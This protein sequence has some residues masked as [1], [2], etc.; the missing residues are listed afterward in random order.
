MH[1]NCDFFR[2]V[3]QLY[4]QS[5]YVCLSDRPSC[6]SHFS[7]QY[8]IQ[9]HSNFMEFQKPFIMW[10]DTRFSLFRHIG[11]I[12][13]LW[14]P[15]MT[16]LSGFWSLSGILIIVLYTLVMWVS[17]HYVIC[18]NVH[19]ILAIWWLENGPNWWFLNTIWATDHGIHLICDVY[20]GLEREFSYFWWKLAKFGPSGGRKMAVVGGFGQFLEY[21]SLKSLHTG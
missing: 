4:K 20:T 3:E 8:V 14:W 5:M 2:Y 9:F 15:K 16:V 13:V 18:G 7:R 12:A 11:Q 19:K 1:K 6:V 21:R 10:E 17:K